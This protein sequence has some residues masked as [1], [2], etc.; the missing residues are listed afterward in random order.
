MV[1]TYEVLYIHYRIQLRNRSA[2]A[3]DVRLRHGSAGQEAGPH[4]R[5]Q[6]RLRILS[7][8]DRALQARPDGVL[9]MY[10][11]LVLAIRRLPQSR[12][13][14]RSGSRALR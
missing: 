1:S 2:C 11:R 14:F 12:T 13:A 10:V 5:P 8:A 7:Q 4:Q 9:R 6:Q 3:P